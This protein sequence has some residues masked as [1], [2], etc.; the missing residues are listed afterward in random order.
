MA[1]TKSYY[2]SLYLQLFF[3]KDAYNQFDF[4]SDW[5]SLADIVE[6]NYINPALDKDSGVQEKAM[7]LAAGMTDSVKIIQRLYDFVRLEILT[8]DSGDDYYLISPGA[9]KILTELRGTGVRKNILL[10]LMLRKLGFT[11]NPV[12][13]CTRS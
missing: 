7:E 6:K 2:A 9:S 4:I 12:L 10:T 3:F 1:A 5:T 13:I 11:A 8:D